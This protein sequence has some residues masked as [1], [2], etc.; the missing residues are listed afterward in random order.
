M[1]K[2]TSFTPASLRLLAIVAALYLAQGVPFGMAMEML[3][4]LLRRDGASLAA[5]AWLPLVGLPWV[6]KFLWAPLVDN[7]WSARLGR[8]RSWILPMQAIVT[9][10]FLV[11]AAIRLSGETAA[12]SV[13]LLVLASLASAT[14]DTATD[15]LAAERF[16]GPMLGRVNAVQV[17]STMIGFFVGGAGSLILA[18]VFGRRLATLAM[19]ALAGA[20]LAMAMALALKDPSGERAMATG[21]PKASLIRLLRRSGAPYVLAIALLSAMTASAGFGLGKLFLVDQDWPLERIGGFGM[22]AGIATV[23]LGCGGAAWAIGR[24]GVWPVLIAGLAA[25]ASGLLLWLGMAAGLLAAAPGPV[26]AAMLLGAIGSGSASVGSMT[27]AMSF[28]ARDGQ[29]GTDMTTVQSS[30]DLGEIG[31][32][33]SLTAIAGAA[34]YPGGFLAGVLIAAAAGACALKATRPVAGATA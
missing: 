25:C 34:G 20:S 17:A 33:A 8:R 26:L 6:L 28:A 27:I 12:V 9:T 5:L 10:S 15:G 13:G 24:F 3:P 30:R 31:T 29:A 19:A 16:A 1:S 11:L 14:Q 18:G 23:V 21:T 4:T 22:T 32:S 7:H 2:H